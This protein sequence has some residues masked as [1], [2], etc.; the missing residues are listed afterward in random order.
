MRPHFYLRSGRQEI[1]PGQIKRSVKVRIV[2]FLILVIAFLGLSFLWFK[3]ATLP[4][5]KN[6]NT[7]QIFVINK[8]DSVREIATNLRD[9]GLIR[10]PLAFFIL[11]KLSGVETGI[12][13]GDFRLNP[14]LTSQQ[15]LEELQHGTLDVWVTIPE[16]WRVEEIAL[17]LAQEM[18]IPEQEFL[19]YSQEG[20]MFPDTYLFPR[21]SSAADLAQIMRDNFATKV[22]NALAEQIKTSDYSLP[23]ILTIAS[24]VEREAKHP[25]DRPQVASVILNRLKTGMKLDIDATVQYVLG[26]QPAE[27]SWWKKALTLDDLQ[28]KSAYNTYL[29]P[30]LPPAPIANPGRL[31][32]EAVLN[33]A[34]TDYLYYV[35]DAEGYNH[36]GRTFEEHQANIA[37]Y[38][39]F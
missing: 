11:I 27:K 2:V 37:K 23:E 29:N 24:L 10:D 38:L 12:Q 3:Q 8:G 22:T 9:Q 13:A 1:P 32:I 15:I 14:A 17:E 20:Q 28:V 16:G 21:E 30:G 25:E 4:V 5:D 39:R 35:S 18:A 19:K 36:Y 33:P 34:E 6:K 26:Y 7:A 31:A